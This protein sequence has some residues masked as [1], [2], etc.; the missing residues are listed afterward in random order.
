MTED[1]QI[2]AD[3]MKEI[4]AALGV[5]LE[6]DEEGICSFQIGDKAVITLEVSEDFP[7]VYIY[8]ALVPL[9]KTEE[10]AALMSRALELNAFQAMTRGGSIAMAPGGG[11]LIFCYSTPIAGVDATIFS[12]LLGT[13]FETVSELKTLLAEVSDPLSQKDRGTTGY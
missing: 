6:L 12:N 4:S 11:V 7:E 5:E 2:V 8:S 1:K 9:P 13:F 10:A 3:W